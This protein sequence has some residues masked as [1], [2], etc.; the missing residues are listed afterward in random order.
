M[1]GS[2]IWDPFQSKVLQ[3]T[4]KRNKFWFVELGNAAHDLQHGKKASQAFTI[5]ASHVVWSGPLTLRRTALTG[6]ILDK[7][8]FPLVTSSRFPNCEDGDFMSLFVHVPRTAV[9]GARA[10]QPKTGAPFRAG[11][12]RWTLFVLGIGRLAW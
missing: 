5:R 11:G 12:P 2:R 6:P 10:A 3:V 9:A 4:V 8:E 7:S 1:L